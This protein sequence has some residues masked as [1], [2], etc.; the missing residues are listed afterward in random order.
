MMAVRWAAAM[1]ECTMQIQRLRGIQTKTKFPFMFS[2]DGFPSTT[3]Y[4]LLSHYLLMLHTSKSYSKMGGL[5]KT[6]F[7]AK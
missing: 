5:I 4:I 3:V 2:L 1:L 6:G 7:Q